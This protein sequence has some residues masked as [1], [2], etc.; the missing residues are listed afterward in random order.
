[1]KIQQKISQTSK[2]RI[3][4]LKIIF[5]KYLSMMPA[6]EGHIFMPS[7]TTT[8]IPTLEVVTNALNVI[9]CHPVAEGGLLTTNSSTAS[10]SLSSDK[11]PVIWDSLLCW[12]EVPAGYVAKIACSQVFQ[13]MG[14][15]VPHDHNL[16]QGEPC[17][18]HIYHCV[19]FNERQ[20][21]IVS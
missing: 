15:P 1:M 2:F 10:Y 11:C 8:P 16:F 7:S 9:N 19:I 14:V 12:N 13:V 20:A 5:M 4:S 17:V 18:K 3:L 6:V 21:V